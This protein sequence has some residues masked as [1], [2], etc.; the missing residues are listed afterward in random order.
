MAWHQLAL[1][2]GEADLNKVELALHLEHW[3]HMFVKQIN[4]VIFMKVV[5]IALVML[6]CSSIS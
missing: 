6:A 5:F 1:S 2:H 3:K 4:I